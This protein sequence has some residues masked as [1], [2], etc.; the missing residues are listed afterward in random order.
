MK[1]TKG[2]SLCST[3]G[4]TAGVGKPLLPPLALAAERRA[5]VGE[6]N[7]ERVFRKA[8]LRFGTAGTEAGSRG[9]VG[10]LDVETMES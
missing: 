4:D 9:K 7:R 8:D 6:A 2:S 5:E 1:E 10:S 3:E